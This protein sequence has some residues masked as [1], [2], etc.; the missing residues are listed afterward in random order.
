MRS[1]R[2]GKDREKIKCYGNS[3]TN[4]GPDEGYSYY[5]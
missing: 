5:L 1:L 4:A 2:E 3:T